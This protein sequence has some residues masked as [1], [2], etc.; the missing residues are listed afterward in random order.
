MSQNNTT[1]NPIEELFLNANQGEAMALLTRMSAA[2][3]TSTGFLTAAPM[4]QHRD[5]VS[6]LQLHQSVGELSGQIEEG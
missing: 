5:I 4:M 3:L 1:V 6:I 2:Y